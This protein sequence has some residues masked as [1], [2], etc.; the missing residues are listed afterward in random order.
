ML[1][2]P[3]NP[4]KKVGYAVAAVILLLLTAFATRCAQGADNYMQFGAGSAI[5]RGAT[6][7]ISITAVFPDK[8]RDTDIEVGA[9][10]LGE[11]SFRE[12]V[13]RNNFAWRATLVDGFG[14][15]QV[16]LGAAYLQ[17]TDEYNGSQL[18]FHLMLGYR[19]E[20][21]PLSVRVEH[22]SNGGTRMPNRGRDMLLVYYRF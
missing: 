12:Q 15:F 18:N 1:N 6:P 9:T 8:I 20:K 5:V 11:S 22:F 3:F 21:I 14:H 10:F 4:G 7:S 19:F 17:N 2:L 16:G 13:Q